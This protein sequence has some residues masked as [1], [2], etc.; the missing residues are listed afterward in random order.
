MK[1]LVNLTI[2]VFACLFCYGQD[3]MTVLPDSGSQSFSE[4]IGIRLFIEDFSYKPLNENLKFNYISYN[5]GFAMTHSMNVSGLTNTP[6]IGVGLE[7]DF[8]NNFVLH[9]FDV[10]VGY[11]SNT[12]N[13]N[14]GIGA[15][16][17]FNLNKAKT[18]S[19]KANA[20][21]FY[22][23]IMYFLGSYYDTTLQ[24]FDING[25]NIGTY[26]RDVEYTN[27]LLCAT[28]GLELYYKRAKWDYF[29]G[30]GYLYTLLRREKV[31]FYYANVPVNQAIY[32][33]GAPV[34]GN[35]IMPGSYLLQA[36]IVREFGL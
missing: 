28:A 6:N 17:S 20:N 5:T 33:N 19:L 30:A 26:I 8:D 34:N 2:S 3:I 10:S 14:L 24:G 27:N 25:L 21:L 22:E 16:Y 18:F 4:F 11:I 32:S 7:H 35:I 15:G 1:K 31:N 13:W 12:L 29:I 9:F 23:N 36:G